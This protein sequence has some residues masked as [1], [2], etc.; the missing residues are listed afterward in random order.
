MYFY[1]KSSKILIKN[2]QKVFNVCTGIKDRW[3]V[4]ATEYRNVLTMYY[5]T[6]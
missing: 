2:K 6:I 4:N 3:E 5:S 1:L